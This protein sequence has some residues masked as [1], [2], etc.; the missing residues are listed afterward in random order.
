[1]TGEPGAERAPRPFTDGRAQGQDV[2][3]LGEREP[4]PLLAW[5]G[6]NPTLVRR[7]ASGQRPV[8]WILGFGFVVGLAADAGG[9]LLKTW[10]T[11]EP[12][13]LVGDL[14]YTLGWALWTGAVVVVFV[15]IWPEVKRRQYKQALDAYEAA[16]GDQARAGNVAAMVNLGALLGEQGEEDQ[17]MQWYRKAGN[18]G[19]TSAMVSLGVLLRKQGKEDQAMQWYRKAADAG[20]TSAM[21]SLGA[22]LAEQGEEDQAVQWYR[23]AADAGNVAA[24]VNLGALL[25]AQGEEDQAVQWY[26]KAADAGD[27]AAMVNLGALLRKQGEEDQAVQWYRKAADA[28]NAAAAVNL[29]ALLAEQGKED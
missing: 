4:D 12:W 7:L 29:G 22:L 16:V 2:L 14:I 23:K 28:G 18:A 10:A 3:G 5:V 27:A 9:F 17:A 20:N 11:R 13:L 26:R 21:V 24:M 25:A 8:Y 6:K 1:M 19:N 15:Q